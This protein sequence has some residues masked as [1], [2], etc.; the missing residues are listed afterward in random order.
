M[1]LIVALLIGLLFAGGVYGLLRRSMV[2]MIAGIMLLSQSINL[3]VFFSGGL[4]RGRP[5]ILSD[6]A[7]VDPSQFA[8]PLPQALVLTAIVI[9][10][11]LMAFVMVLFQ[12]T[13]KSLGS[14]DTEQFLNT[15]T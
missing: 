7:A 3:L 6:G 10:L 4:E 8:D 12:K 15:D 9:G 13:F 14:D 1:E 5:P 2:R 11:G